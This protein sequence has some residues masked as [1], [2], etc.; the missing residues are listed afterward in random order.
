MRTV[1]TRARAMKV[2]GARPS[3]PKRAVKRTVGI[4]DG[5]M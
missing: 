4:Q 1:E 2:E 3:K 5:S